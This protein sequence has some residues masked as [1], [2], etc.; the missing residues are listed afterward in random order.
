MSTSTTIKQVMRELAALESPKMRE[1]QGPYSRH[2]H[3]DVG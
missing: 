2:D 1:A 3:E